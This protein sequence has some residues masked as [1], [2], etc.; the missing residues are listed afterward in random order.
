MII[1]RHENVPTKLVG[2]GAG[3]R[4]TAQRSTRQQQ[5]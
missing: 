5:Q 1:T 2:A 3:A 4:V